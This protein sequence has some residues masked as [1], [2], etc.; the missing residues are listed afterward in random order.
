MNEAFAQIL[1]QNDLFA[2]LSGVQRSEAASRALRRHYPA[3][4]FIA[5]Y[6]D[7]WPYLFMVSSGSVDALKLS[8]DGRQLIVLTLKPGELFWGLAFFNDGMKTPV[9]LVA[10]EATDLYIWSREA[11][12]PLLLDNPPAL[13]SLCQKMVVRMAQ[14]SQMLEGF[15][16]YPVSGRLARFLLDRFSDAGEPS[17]ERSLTLDDI[18][19]RIGST[20]EMVCRALYQLSDKNF[21]RITRTEFT[22]IDEAG[23]A[24]IAERG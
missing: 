13:W 17:L 24:E 4:A 9:A 10:Q 14:A 18:A 2:R 5:Q 6:G 3:G 8:G 12:L 22:L 7:V 16:F 21:I 20:R 23:L 11:L 15:A 1:A 19:A